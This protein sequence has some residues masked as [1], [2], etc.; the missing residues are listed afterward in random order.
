[1]AANGQ[2]LATSR[3][4][5]LGVETDIRSNPPPGFLGIR[6][7]NTRLIYVLDEVS[8]DILRSVYI[9]DP[10]VAELDWFCSTSLDP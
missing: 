5:K 2:V 8:R 10:I 9:T 3:W 1:M 4:H 6:Q 7:P